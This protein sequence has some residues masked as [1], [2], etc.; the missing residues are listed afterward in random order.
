MLCETCLGDNP[1]G[2]MVK[3]P[4]G[5]KP[6]KISG[7]PFQGFRWKAGAAGRYKETI[8]SPVVA[9]EKNIC[10][11]C[12][13]DLQFGLPVGL[14][15]KMLAQGEASSAVVPTSVVG[16]QF[17]YQNLQDNPE[18]MQNQNFAL[19]MQNNP[20]MLQLDRFSKVA[21]NHPAGAGAGSSTAAAAAAPTQS[22][23]AAAGPHTTAWRN[24]PKLCSFWLDGRC[25]RVSRK[26]CPFRPC[27]GVFVF[28]E[29]ASQFREVNTALVQRLQAEGPDKVMTSMGA[30]TRDAFRK[31]ISGKNREQ[32]IRDRVAGTDDLSQKYHNKLK[33]MDI[34][35]K[36]PE[37]KSI[38]T[39]WLG[40]IDA[41]V[42]DRELFGYLYRVGN[43]RKINVLPASKCAFV[44]FD[45]R[46]SAENAARLLHNNLSIRGKPATVNWAKGK[47]DKNATTGAG[48]GAETVREDYSAGVYAIPAPPG[49]ERA[50]VSSYALNIP[51]PPP[52][53]PPLGHINNN[54]S[55]NSSSNSNSNSSNNS[56]NKRSLNTASSEEHAAKRHAP[57][58][59]AS[60][61]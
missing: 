7:L 38:C 13:F 1:Y 20:S 5:S 27:C 52:P 8:I 28:P 51:S 32:A 2:R 54:N 24:L 30:E 34:E 10:Q 60:G 50:P 21:Y 39:L 19:S 3:L 44:D 56:S 41:D 48:T 43:I 22:P 14:R 36:A 23:H 33:A 16:L 11:S 61:H 4:Y 18:L 40:N 12:L 55:S 29:L 9:R 58:P 17:H 59:E 45:S 47:A 25:N 46:D 53:P 26:T 35:L 57:E 37:D 42:T 15:D 31:P 49:M 6:C